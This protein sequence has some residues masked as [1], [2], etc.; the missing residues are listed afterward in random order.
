MS[1]EGWGRTKAGFPRRV[2][3]W[4]TSSKYH[5]MGFN[6]KGLTTLPAGFYLLV[7]YLQSARL[8]RGRQQSV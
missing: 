8:I 5:R 2:R 7:K 3:G 6:P 1:G 4:K